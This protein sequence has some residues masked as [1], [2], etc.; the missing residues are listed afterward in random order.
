MSIYTYLEVGHDLSP[1]TKEIIFKY[2]YLPS[3]PIQ[4]SQL[5]G[6]KK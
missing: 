3:I 6:I 2:T 4:L 5:K 1:M